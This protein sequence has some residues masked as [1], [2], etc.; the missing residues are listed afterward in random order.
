[1][2]FQF[3]TTAL[4]KKN[5]YKQLKT[6]DKQSIMCFFIKVHNFWLTFGI[7]V[8][9]RLCNFVQPFHHLIQVFWTLIKKEV[10]LFTLF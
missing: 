8:V 3:L 2:I 5:D 9:V 6:Q 10:F 4:S 1:M 7:L